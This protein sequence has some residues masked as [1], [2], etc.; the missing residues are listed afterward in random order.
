MADEIHQFAQSQ[1]EADVKVQCFDGL[2][3]NAETECDV[4]V[5]DTLDEQGESLA[6]PVGKTT[7]SI[8]APE[9]PHAEYST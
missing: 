6:F 3:A 4:L 2:T 1:L 8:S 9:R 7:L 5:D